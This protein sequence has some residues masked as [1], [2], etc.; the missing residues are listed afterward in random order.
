MKLKNIVM[1]LLVT[2]LS[3]QTVNAQA[4]NCEDFD[5]K[6]SLVNPISDCG[7]SGQF[8]TKII[9]GV[10][11]FNV[12]INEVYGDGTGTLTTNNRTLN[13]GIYPGT[14]EIKIVDANGCESIKKFSIYANNFKVKTLECL[15]NGRRKVRFTNTSN[16]FLTVNAE[17]L[18]FGFSLSSG[19]SI[20][21]SLPAGDYTVAV[22]R[23]GCATYEVGFG[24]AS[25]GTSS[26]QVADVKPV[27]QV[28]T[29]EEDKTINDFG[30]KVSP[31]PT[32]RLITIDLKNNEIAGSV[33]AIIYDANGNV[34]IREVIDTNKKSINVENLKK[35]LYIINYTDQ[36][37]ILIHQDKIIKN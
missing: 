34:V 36:N 7:T 13:L 19:A 32:T 23:P 12:T 6:L 24:V 10:A 35:G 21:V 9:G 20:N 30:I 16:S 3:L 25:C 18:G 5:Q 27:Q 31:N 1:L 17:I 11:P 28:I 37:N 2:V 14:F 29:I 8:R 15:A 33:N 22:S 26:K 4:N